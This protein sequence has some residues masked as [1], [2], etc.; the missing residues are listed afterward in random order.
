M[1]AQREYR[2][3]AGFFVLPFAKNDA[4]VVKDCHSERMM[5]DYITGWMVA[6]GTAQIDREHRLLLSDLLV[7]ARRD[8]SV[9]Y[10]PAPD[11]AP[12][13][14]ECVE[15]G[16]LAPLEWGPSGELRTRLTVPEGV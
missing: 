5:A 4:T 11:L 10:C 13:L 9:R 6:Y 1:P 2:G 8:G 14:V 12:L 15:A 7:C 3:S 16:W